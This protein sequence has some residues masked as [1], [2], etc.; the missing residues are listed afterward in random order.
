MD[1]RS[2]S[3]A[4]LL[5]STISSVAE[6]YFISQGYKDIKSGMFNAIARHYEIQECKKICQPRTARIFM[7][8]LKAGEIP[9]WVAR[10]IDLQMMELAAS[11]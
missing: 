6:S 7:R 10:E 8:L 2:L 3:E 5:T 9:S 11:D 1:D 4:N